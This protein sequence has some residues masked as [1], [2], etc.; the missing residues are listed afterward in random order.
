MTAGSGRNC[1]VLE[2]AGFEFALELF[3]LAAATSDGHDDGGRGA[4]REAPG[5][6]DAGWRKPV[7]VRSG[8]GEDES[9]FSL[10]A[11]GRAF[12]RS[13]ADA[14]LREKLSRRVMPRS[15]LWRGLPYGLCLDAPQGPWKRAM[16][17]AP[18]FFPSS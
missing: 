8:A 16:T 5:E 13:L 14:S 4:V 18:C 15:L 11:G 12:L 1:D 9:A 10:M 6:E 17:S 3:I 7:V 2:P